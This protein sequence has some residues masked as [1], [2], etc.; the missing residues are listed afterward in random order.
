[1]SS[2]SNQRGLPVSS[3]LGGALG[4]VFLLY[5]LWSFADHYRLKQN[6]A[7]LQARVTSV[8][9]ARRKG[10][11]SYDVQYAFDVAGKSYEGEGALSQHTFSLLRIGGP[12][13]VRYAATNPSIS[14]PSEMSHDQAS[15]FLHGAIGIPVSLLI[16]FA[17]LRKNQSLPKQYRRSM[18]AADE[19]P[20][21][22]IEL[23]HGI[24]G[25][26][27]TVYPVI[28][29][30]RARHFYE[31]ELGLRVTT[32]LRDEWVEYHLWDNCFAITTMMKDRVRPSADSGGSIALEVREIDKFVS[33]LERKGVQ[34]KVPPFSTPVCRMAVL[35]DPEGNAL[36]L[37]E[38][39]A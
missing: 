24:S 18:A 19:G 3:L 17:A 23:P 6:G 27:F 12:L 31:E 29:M 36:T 22:T 33:E 39:N 28:D 34:I 1:M 20:P 37:H 32:N 16:L 2:E 7:T 35:I 10:G 14:E 21:V 8:S 13:D 26:A 38:R 15:L 9:I 30:K 4:I 5:N 11:I 25:I